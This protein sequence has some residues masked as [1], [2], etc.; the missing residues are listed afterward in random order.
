MARGGAQD[1]E[2]AHIMRR[3]LICGARDWADVAPIAKLINSLP[4]DAIVIHGRARG[5]DSIAD[6]AARGRR[7]RVEG[8]SA[9]WLQFG[10]EAGSRR[11][12]RMIDVGEP[13]EGHA[14]P[15]V[16]SIG[17]WD[18]VR[19]LVS[20]GI[21]TL[22]YRPTMQCPFC[23]LVYIADLDQ[24]TEHCRRLHGSQPIES[25]SSLRRQLVQSE[26]IR[27]MPALRVYDRGAL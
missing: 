24:L 1:L 10:S 26:A 6:R 14:F 3:V 2:A 16:K 20:A 7:L 19:R 21:P 23:G 18:M 4:A 17:T 13:T 9:D 22:I 12:Q 5:A 15:T 25:M 27:P 8:Y 11:N